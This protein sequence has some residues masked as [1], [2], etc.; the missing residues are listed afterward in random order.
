M[1]NLYDNE[2]YKKGFRL[3][4]RFGYNFQKAKD[5]V[6]DEEKKNFEFGYNDGCAR[7]MGETYGFSEDY[8]DY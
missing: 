3:G 8:Y 1:K 7:Y 4:Y 6:P 5:K 2:Y